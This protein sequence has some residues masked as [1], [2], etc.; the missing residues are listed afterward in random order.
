MAIVTGTFTPWS[1]ALSAGAAA[2]SVALA[3]WAWGAPVPDPA[4][5]RVFLAVWC[6]AALALAALG[7]CRVPGALGVFALGGLLGAALGSTPW[8][9][10]DAVF[11]YQLWW[12]VP[13][14]SGLVLAVRGARRGRVGGP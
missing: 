13:V 6:A 4:A 3:A 8:Q 9:S 10:L 7:S 2:A 14:A 12:T 5:H 11:W 1:A